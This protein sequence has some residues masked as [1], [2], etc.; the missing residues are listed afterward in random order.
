MNKFELKESDSTPHIVLDLQKQIFKIEGKSF[1]EDSREFYES[2]LEWF[3]HLKK[4][5]PSTIP[6]HIN[7]FYI[8][9]ASYISI[10]Q[11]LLKL[12]EIQDMGTAVS[13][14]WQYDEDDDDIKKTGEDYARLTKLNFEFV[15]NP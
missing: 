7:L 5:Q 1:P 11:I 13:I 4:Q 15:I 14:I 12:V 9:S 2:T 3:E 6:L 10:K 8:N